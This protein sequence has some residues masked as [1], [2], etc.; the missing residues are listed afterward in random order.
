MATMM[1]HDWAL[2]GIQ[3]TSVHQQIAA[4]LNISQTEIEDVYQCTPLQEA[5]ITLSTVG[6]AA[7][8]KRIVLS[9]RSDIDLP[10]FRSAVQDV[11]RATS[12]LRTRI[13]QFADISFVQVVLNESIQWSSEN[14]T[15]EEF[16]E[17]GQAERW[18]IGDPLLRHS[19]IVDSQVKA[20]W[21]VWTIHHAIYD[22]WS[23]PI[24]AEHVSKRYNNE[25]IEPTLQYNDFVRHILQSD[26]DQH[27]AYWRWSLAGNSYTQFSL[28]P[29]QSYMPNM[30]STF[31]QYCR[32]VHSPTTSLSGMILSLHSWKHQPEIL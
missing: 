18:G 26:S 6:S 10:K 5:L 28:L 16:L 3:G 1:P 23:F 32:P 24:M 7:Y 30:D 20:R 9:L 29:N 27:G 2:D 12:I 25:P 15:L 19:L 22:G 13:V 4:S 21:F 31:E 11:V 17:K 8:V 14:G